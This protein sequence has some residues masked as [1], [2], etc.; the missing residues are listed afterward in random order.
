MADTAR[1]PSR[2]LIFL[3]AAL[4]RLAIALG[5]GGFDP[6]EQFDMTLPAHPSSHPRVRRA[7]RRLSSA[8]GLDDDRTFAL[9][10]VV[11]EAI[12]NVIEHAYGSGAAD[13]ILR[14][15]ARREGDAVVVEVRDQGR[16]R[17]DRP[18]GEQR[19]RGILLMRGLADSVDIRSAPSGTTVRL[20]VSSQASPGAPR[21]EPERGSFR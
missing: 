9:Q 11:G 17:S 21:S 10:V 1:A 7:L 19:G 20:A 5:L 2:G 14:V 3:S 12:N 15:V 8:A 6:A 16:W 18:D 13:G 4:R